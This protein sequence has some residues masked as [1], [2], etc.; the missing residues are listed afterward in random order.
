MLLK[1][2]FLLKDLRD[3]VADMEILKRY[4]DIARVV[5]P[6][7]RRVMQV[8]LQSGESEEIPFCAGYCHDFWEADNP[9]RNCIAMRSVRE[10]D[11]FVKLEFVRD[12]VYLVTAIPV[13][14][15]DGGHVALEL[16]K[17]VTGQSIIDGL[18]GSLSSGGTDKLDLRQSIMNL[19]DLVMRDG[20]TGLMNR[21]FMDEKLPLQLVQGAAEEKPVAV[22]LADIDHFKRINDAY[23][24][25]I[26]D[27][28]L[29]QLAAIFTSHIRESKGD[30]AAR[31]GGE[32]FLICLPDC[33]IDEAAQVAERLRCA[34]ETAKVKTACGEIV[35]T[36]SIGIGVYKGDGTVEGVIGQADRRL[37]A[38]KRGGRNRTV[39]RD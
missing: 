38:A 37:Y 29:R 13:R 27:E 8:G 35:V 39:F 12:Q 32:E 14:K 26:G 16:L 3:V 5:D 1:E 30:W 17:D 31:Y 22:L 6:L 10:V 28:V 21:R 11:T 2:V 4:Y 34:V 33:D 19:N 9:C 25:L 23:G 20:L 7:E 18:L 36:V 15:S 24:H